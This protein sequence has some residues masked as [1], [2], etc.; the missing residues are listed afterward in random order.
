MR[1]YIAGDRRSCHSHATAL[2]RLDVRFFL[3]IAAFGQNAEICAKRKVFSFLGRI[4]DYRG[5][6]VTLGRVGKSA[7]ATSPIL[8]LYYRRQD[9]ELN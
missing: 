4:I 9:R 7:E 8:L 2:Q 3:L 6:Y 1:Y 5:E